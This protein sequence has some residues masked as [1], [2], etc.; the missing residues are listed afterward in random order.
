L[1]GG[2]KAYLLEQAALQRQ[3]AAARDAASLELRHIKRQQEA[4]AG[5]RVRDRLIDAVV[6]DTILKPRARR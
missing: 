1:A 4:A 3:E 2:E 5:S 6:L